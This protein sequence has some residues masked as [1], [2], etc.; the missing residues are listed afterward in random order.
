MAIFGNDDNKEINE[1]GDASP[2][3]DEADENTGAGGNPITPEELSEEDG[4]APRY[5][6]GLFSMLTAD[7]FTQEENY[8]DQYLKSKGLFKEDDQE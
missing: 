8:S 3:L 4:K 1:G 6:K 7:Q 5:C 2:E